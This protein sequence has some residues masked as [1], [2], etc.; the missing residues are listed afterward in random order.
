MTYFNPD[1]SAGA[2]VPIGSVTWFCDNS[3]PANFLECDGSAINRLTYAQLF[4]V[5]G[6]TFGIGDGVTT[7]N[8]PDNDD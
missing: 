7:F 3:P 1:V 5:I 6:T 2:D 8:I 4:A